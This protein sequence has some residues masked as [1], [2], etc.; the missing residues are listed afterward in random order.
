MKIRIEKPFLDR[1][2][3]PIAFQQNEYLTVPDAVG[4]KLIKSG[5]ATNVETLRTKSAFETR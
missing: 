1:A 3:S 2:V 4:K 5:H